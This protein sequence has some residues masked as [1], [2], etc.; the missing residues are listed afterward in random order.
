MLTV[1]PNCTSEL[2]GK[3]LGAISIACPNCGS[4]LTYNI[5]PAEGSEW[6][7]EAS[8][9]VLAGAMAGAHH[10]IGVV[11]AVITG[12]VGFFLLSWQFAYKRNRVPKDWP[13]WRQ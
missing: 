4:R 13:R 12:A 9:L 10:F 11:A 5:H 8:L 6:P 7:G 1:C 3:Y 2:R